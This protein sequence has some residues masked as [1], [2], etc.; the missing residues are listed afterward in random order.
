MWELSRNLDDFNKKSIES[1]AFTHLILILY[2]N[3]NL[4]MDVIL[5]GKVTNGCDK[6]FMDFFLMDHALLSKVDQPW[7]CQILQ[8]SKYLCPMNT[9]IDF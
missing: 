8:R 6:S 3:D 9:K 4:Q 7:A 5:V 1:S 2:Q